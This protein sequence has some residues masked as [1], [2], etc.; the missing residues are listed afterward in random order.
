MIRMHYFG[1]SSRHF[2]KFGKLKQENPIWLP[3]VVFGGKNLPPPIAIEEFKLD[4]HGSGNNLFRLAI[5]H[6]KLI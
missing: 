6:T 4:L 3:I 1:S 5:G 2:D